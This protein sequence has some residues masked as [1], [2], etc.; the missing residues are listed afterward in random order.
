MEVLFY[1]ENEMMCQAFAL[2]FKQYEMKVI[3][4][5]DFNEIDY[6]LEEFPAV[7]IIVD[8]DSVEVPQDVALKLSHCNKTIM[9]VGSNTNFQWEHFKL[10]VNPSKLA[11]ILA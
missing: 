6:Q 10:P 7:A 1:S 8:L 9:T 3:D 4:F 2:A 11:Q 5:G